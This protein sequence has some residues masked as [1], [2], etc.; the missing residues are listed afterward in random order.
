LCRAQSEARRWISTAQAGIEEVGT[1]IGVAVA[2]FQHQNFL[3]PSR[4][5]VG[6]IK[7]LVL[8]DVVVEIFAHGC[9]L[10]VSW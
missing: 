5:Q 3:A 4:A 10:V 2:G 9:K 6:F 8:P 7:I 1:G